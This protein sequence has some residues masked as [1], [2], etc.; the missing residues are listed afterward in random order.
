LAGQRAK[1]VLP[2]VT[3]MSS[4]GIEKVDPMAASALQMAHGEI[5]LRIEAALRSDP[6]RPDRQLARELEIKRKAIA[7]IRALLEAQGQI[8]ARPP[9]LFRISR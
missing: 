1:S 2:G 5:H 8:P 3:L 7:R 4:G 9:S 6:L